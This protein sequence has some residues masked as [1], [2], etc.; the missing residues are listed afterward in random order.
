MILSRSERTT[1][2]H[3]ECAY[4]NPYFG[5]NTHVIRFPCC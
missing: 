5:T 3:T 2:R 1:L 4:Y